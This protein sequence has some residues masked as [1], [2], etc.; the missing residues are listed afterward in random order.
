MS[1]SFLGF[2]SLGHLAEEQ[3]WSAVAVLAALLD[4]RQLGGEAGLGEGDMADLFGLCWP[5]ASLRELLGQLVDARV[6]ERDQG[7]R[8][9]V[10]PGAEDRLS[11]ELRALMERQ[12]LSLPS[13]P[14]AIKDLL[15]GFAGYLERGGGAV[16][17]ARD[18]S[19]ASERVFETGKHLSRILPRPFP[20]VLRPHPHDFTAWFCLLSADTAPLI[21]E[22]Y[23][24][25]SALRDRL[26]L[27]DLERGLKIN[28]THSELFV[29][30]ERYLQRNHRLRLHPPPALD[31]SLED[32]GL[33]SLR[34]G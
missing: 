6:L 5:A 1:M 27:Y 26:A 15:A 11:R 28:L 19:G 13:G 18:A 4:A 29:H 7:G 20:L 25:K 9:Q 34:M 32:Y 31:Q 3:S 12:T 22:A 14:L 23:M 2:E 33:L 30:F 21:I 24:K 16:T 8:Y 17:V 10:A